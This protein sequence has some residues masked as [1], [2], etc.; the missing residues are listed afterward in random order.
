MN[1]KEMIEIVRELAEF[2]PW[3]EGWV[4]LAEVGVELA[5]REIEYKVDKRTKLIDFIY[6]Y[7]NVL[8]VKRDNCQRAPIYYVKVRD[9][10]DGFAP[11]EKTLS[12]RIKAK[13]EILEWAFW[14][15][16]KTVYR[17]LKNKALPERW[18]YKKQN[19]NFH[20]P[21]L[22]N[23]L[24]YTF[25]RLKKEGKIS[26]TENY[27]AFNTGL[28]DKN[29]EPIY[30]LF[31]RNNHGRQPWEFLNFCTRVEN[32][33]KILT[34]YFEEPPARAQY[35]NEISEIIYDVRLKRPT[36]NVEHIISENGDR[37]PLEFLK[38][39]T[40]GIIELK[41]PAALDYCAREKY[42]QDLAKA[43]RNNNVVY[44]TLMNRINDAV[45]LAVK[46]AEWNFKTAIPMYFPTKNNISILLPLSLVVD[47]VVDLALVVEKT[48]ANNYLG[49]TVIPLSWAYSNARLITRPDSD[50]LVAKNIDTDSGDGEN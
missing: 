31:I 19:P 44:R 16:L 46:K 8:F 35:Y 18:Y 5:K 24:T 32:R 20:D 43:T 28:V 37:L 40:Q 49:H 2:K 41:D 42:R 38:R 25:Y 26:E 50:W 7:E 1:A 36:A 22:V 48:N 45:D 13:D 33:G 3:E 9:G 47:E 27:A 15:D 21:I 30:A 12:K 34:E 6:N 14:H 10:A 17:E 23:Y 29:Y 39:Y 4:N 11:Q